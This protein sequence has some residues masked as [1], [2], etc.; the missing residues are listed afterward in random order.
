VPPAAARQVSL[1]FFE[2]ASWYREQWELKA[3]GKEA[4][5]LQ[6]DLRRRGHAS[7]AARR[8]LL[9]GGGQKHSVT[10]RKFRDKKSFPPPSFC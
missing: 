5:F 7:A 8:K 1:P 3:E 10:Q 9:N 6:A 4:A 2:P